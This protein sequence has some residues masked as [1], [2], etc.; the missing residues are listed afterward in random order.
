MSLA[1]AKSDDAAFSYMSIFNVNENV[2]KAMGSSNFETAEWEG[3]LKS[4]ALE[5]EE[6]LK[7]ANIMTDKDNLVPAWLVT[8]RNS[9]GS[10]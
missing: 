4:A 2:R 3:K 8:F 1:K 5:K 6:K 10:L 9:G 7:Y